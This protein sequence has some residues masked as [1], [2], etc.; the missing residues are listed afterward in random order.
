[1]QSLNAQT[2]GLVGAVTARA[3][4]VSAAPPISPLQQEINALY[5]G[6]DGLHTDITALEA[7]LSSVLVPPSPQPAT[8]EVQPHP[9]EVVA[10]IQTMTLSVDNAR[11]R[12]RDLYQR[13]AA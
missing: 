2:V 11:N 6:M 1:M 8:A 12:L 13:I 5:S 7:K 3:D 9:A 10:Q 4:Q